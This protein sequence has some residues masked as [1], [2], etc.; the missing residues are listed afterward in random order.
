MQPRLLDLF[1]QVQVTKQ[2]VYAWLLAVPAI[3]PASPRAASYVR[4][5]GVVQ[6]ITRAK[7]DG[8][9]DTTVLVARASGQYQQLV[10][11][12]SI[13]SNNAFGVG[14]WAEIQRR[15]APRSKRLKAPNRPKA[16]IQREKVRARQEIALRK[17]V[18]ASVLCR[19]PTSTPPLS[20][21]LQD[22]GLPNDAALAKAMG[23]TVRT[24]QKWIHQDKA[25]QAVMLAIYWLTRW[26]VST[27][28]TNAHNDAVMSYGLAKS[29]ERQV[30]DLQ[31]QIKRVER[32]AD[33][34]SANDPLPTI[35]AKPPV[36]RLPTLE[37]IKKRTASPEMTMASKSQFKTEQAA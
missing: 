37:A 19:L 4:D 10:E 15:D 5:Y 33:F 2:D 35:M 7:L 16:V 12:D 11:Q 30:A 20:I 32:L 25:P 24:A 17:K 8:S 3:D 13:A 1:G 26:G 18:K 23:V 14:E 36:S 6:K 9:F 27:I 29:R 21:M 28:D 31:G 34:G 22:I